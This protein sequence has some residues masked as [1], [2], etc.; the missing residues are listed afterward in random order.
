MRLVTDVFPSQ[1]YFTSIDIGT[2][3]ITVKGE[4]DTL[5]TVI[6]YAMA[7]E[8]QE[9]FSEVR[10]AEIDEVGTIGTEENETE[11]PEAEISVITFDI[12]I[13]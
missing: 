1:T 4:T 5:F 8:A 10:I 7:L 13:R 2:D 6:N 3:Q 12:V 9:E 11:A